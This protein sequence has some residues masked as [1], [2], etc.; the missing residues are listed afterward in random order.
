MVWGAIAMAGIG[1]ITSLVKGNQQRSA[2]DAANKEQEKIAEAQ[3]ERDLKEWELNYLQS[4]SDF[5]WQNA[6]VEAQRYQERVRKADYEAQQARIID[7]AVLNLE[8]NSAALMDQYIVGEKLRATQVTNELQDN[9]A[10]EQLKYDDAMMRVGNDARNALLSSTREVEAYMNSVKTRGLQADELLRKKSNEGQ[11]I[12]EQIVIGEQLD[13]LQRDAQYITALVEGADARA[14]ATA[15]QGGSNSSRAVAMDSMKAFG[16]SFSLLKTE[17][18][19]RRRQLNNFNTSLNGESASQM[20]QIAAGI[21]REANA[22]KYT[23]ASTALTMDSLRGQATTALGQYQLATG[24]LMRNFNQLTKPGFAL[25]QRQGQREYDALLN[26]TKNTI[27]GA[28]TPYRE[29]IIFDPLEPIAGLKPEKMITTKVA[30]PGWGSILM[31][32]GVNA[33]QGAMSMSYTKPDGSLGF[34]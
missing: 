24:S 7:A 26:T 1:G 6:N 23:K 19:N 28:S 33:A 27:A 20:A 9:L 13:T 12:Q 3:Y 10:G 16:R 17:Q 29:A 15:R 8:L 4:R 32:A 5:A 11:S 14:G 30:K 31:D 21:E 34:R 2:A 18:K 25:A 22:I